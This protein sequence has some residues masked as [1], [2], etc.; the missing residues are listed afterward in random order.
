MT[1]SWVPK[2]P[3]LRPTPPRVQWQGTGAEP[4]DNDKRSP[5]CGEVWVP[6]LHCCFDFT[7]PSSLA[8]EFEIRND[9]LPT[10]IIPRKT[11][12][13]E[14]HSSYCSHFTSAHLRCSSK[15]CLYSFNLRRSWIHNFL[16]PFAEG[17]K[18]R[19][20]NSWLSLH[21]HSGLLY[22]SATQDTSDLFMG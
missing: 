14:E 18:L 8:A 7:Q 16:L 4:T 11:A 10:N 21:C 19:C 13:A 22:L 15:N 12:Q 6:Y 9:C 5:K 2:S 20:T 17:K 3:F 1:H